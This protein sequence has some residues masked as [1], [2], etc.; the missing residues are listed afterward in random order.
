MPPSHPQWSTACSLPIRNESSAAVLRPSLMRPERADQHAGRLPS[1]RS[2]GLPDL[3]LPPRLRPV[4]V[5]FLST[6]RRDVATRRA[7]RT[8]ECQLCCF[9]ARY[10]GDRGVCRVGL[11]ITASTLAKVLAAIT[12]RL[13]PLSAS[14]SVSESSTADME[15]SGTSTGWKGSRGLSS[16]ATLSSDGAWSRSWSASCHPDRT[17]STSRSCLKR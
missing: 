2:A 9:R 11:F 5:R 15:N 4:L 17:S 14:V 8:P 3:C 12:T 1:P 10:R 7:F 16:D 13:M 6:K